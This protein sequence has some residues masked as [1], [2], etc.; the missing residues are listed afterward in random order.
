MCG[1]CA[2]NPAEVV[3]GVVIGEVIV[4]SFTYR[5]QEGKLTK[6]GFQR[7]S[8]WQLTDTRMKLRPFVDQ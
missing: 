5:Y 3:I 4:A 2:G 8:S 6:K 7:A 1:V